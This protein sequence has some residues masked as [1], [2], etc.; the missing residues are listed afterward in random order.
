[1][2]EENN[3]VG[4]QGAEKEKDIVVGLPSNNFKEIEK[5]SIKHKAGSLFPSTQIKYKKGNS[6]ESKFRRQKMY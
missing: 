6:L 4:T 2:V 1:M 3:K 5:I